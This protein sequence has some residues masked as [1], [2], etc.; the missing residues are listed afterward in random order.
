MIRTRRALS[1]ASAFRNA[2]F[3]WLAL[4]LPLVWVANGCMMKP[5]A[6][7][8]PASP[9]I[10]HPTAPAAVASAFP[11]TLTDS[12]GKTLTLASAPQRIVSISPSNTEILFALGAGDRVVGDTTA[13]DYP[14]EAKA[15]PHV[16]GQG[17][18]IDLEKLQAQNP[19][20]VVAVGAINGKDIETLEAAKV[21]VLTVDPRTVADTYA[22]ITLLGKAT[23]Q[24]AQADKIVADMRAR[25]DAVQKTTAGAKSHPQVLIAYGDNPVYTTGPGSFIDDVIG[26]AGGE[27]IM[28]DAG[29]VIS[30][31]KVVERGP[32]VI[33]CSADLV[34]RL[35]QIPGWAEGVPAVRDARFFQPSQPGI[36]ERPGP[37]LPEAAEELARYLHPELFP[38]AAPAANGAIPASTGTVAGSGSAAASN[39]A[40]GTPPS[41]DSAAPNPASPPAASNAPNRNAAQG[42]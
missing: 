3:L 27:N 6:E 14:V 32:D 37:R 24:N 13:C 11:V 17:G 36:L 16:S 18:H 26:I 40:T 34:E 23:G 1:N 28:H 5:D 8:N 42:H 4:V 15:K 31:E 12:R 41:S 30:P 29:S 33:V 35:R 20:L 21:R 19:D 22:A 39:P 38:G 10:G 9:A 25:L 7:P 2:H